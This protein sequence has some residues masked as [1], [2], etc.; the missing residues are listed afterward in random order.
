MIHSNTQK[1][2]T[3]RIV[4]SDLDKQRCPLQKCRV[5][6]LLCITTSEHISDFHAYSHIQRG[7]GNK[8]VP[9]TAGIRKHNCAI[10]AGGAVSS[11]LLTQG[12]NSQF[13]R[14]TKQTHHWRQA[15]VCVFVYDYIFFRRNIAKCVVSSRTQFRRVR[16]RSYNKS[17]RFISEFK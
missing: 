1:T 17:A 10:K 13:C 3:L 16:A 15:H 11:D 8:L 9:A 5:S 6:A 12:I 7:H 14:Y 2:R 4:C